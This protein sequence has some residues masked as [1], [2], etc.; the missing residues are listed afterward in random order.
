[1]S[2]WDYRR[3]G[4]GSEKILATQEGDV[5][6]DEGFGFNRGSGWGVE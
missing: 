3:N 4:A 5:L 6:Q 2:C 1:L